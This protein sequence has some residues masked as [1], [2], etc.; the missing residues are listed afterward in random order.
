MK[1]RKEQLTLKPFL[2]I[3]ADLDLLWLLELVTNGKFTNLRDRK[4]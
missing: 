4:S 1:N 3:V 2:P